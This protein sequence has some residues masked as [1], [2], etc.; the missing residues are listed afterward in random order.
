MQIIQTE[1]K[2]SYFCCK[3]ADCQTAA[4]TP[5]PIV[6]QMPVVRIGTR[7]SQLALWQANHVATLIA[8]HLTNVT[9]EIVPV[10]TEADRR[11]DI[12]LSELGGK[13]LFIKELEVALL[14]N[15]IDIA[16]HSMK[17]VTVELDDEFCIASILERENPFDA[18]VSTR[19]P[20]LNELP[21]GAL[22]GTCS[23]RR[24]SQL[25]LARPDL[26]IVPVRG[27]V[28]TRLQRLDAGEFDAIILA[29]SGLLR[30]GLGD[31]ITEVLQQS[32]HIPS[33]GQGALGIECRRRDSNLIGDLQ[34]LDDCSSS[35]AVHAERAVN[36]GLGG[37]CH[38][39]IGILAKCRSQT[40]DLT[41]YVG[42]VDGKRTLMESATGKLDE[43]MDGALALIERLNQRG[44][45]E[46]L[47]G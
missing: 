24:Q 44:A 28:T 38:I 12:L 33:P 37:S 31:R 29:V 10:K 42:S 9:T 27:N 45:Q 30:L 36:A 41:T 26:K 19:Y 11:Q 8:K 21:E 14:D 4:G 35:A 2:Y 17:D 32:P 46:I 5:S 34:L 13:G 39:P 3:H 20:S 7:G 16:V 6:I 23:L 15:R 43:L 18:L 22:I 25:L 40:Y 47:A 1:R